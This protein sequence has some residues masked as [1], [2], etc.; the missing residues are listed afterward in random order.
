MA[1]MRTCAFLFPPFATKP[2]IITSLPV[3]TNARVETFATS[4]FVVGSRSYTST[5]PTP[6]LPLLPRIIAVFSAEHARIAFS[7]RAMHSLSS[8]RKRFSQG[9]PI[10]IGQSDAP[11]HLLHITRWMKLIGIVELPAK[12]V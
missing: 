11:A 2:P 6:A 5:R 1:R 12:L 7:F 3:S 9:P 10:Y 8:S 4:E